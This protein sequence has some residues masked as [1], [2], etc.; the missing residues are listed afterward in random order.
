MKFL[1]SKIAVIGTGA[2]GLGILTA[3]LKK[4]NIEI[5]VFDVFEE[6]DF[7]SL[8]KATELKVE[9]FYDEIYSEIK[10]KTSFKFPPPKTHFTKPLAKYKLDGKPGLFKSKSLGGLTNYWGGTSLAFTDNELENWHISRKDLNPYYS[11]LSKLIG[12]SSRNDKLDSYFGEN[13]ATNPPYKITR[14]FDKL[15]ES[16]NSTSENEDNYQVISG[17]NRVA[18]ETREGE[19]NSCIYCGECLA[20]CFSDSIY[21][22]R[23]TIEKYLSDDRVK[24]VKGK[25]IRVEEGKV[26]VSAE[27][28]VETYSGFS[29]IFIGAGCPNSTEIV[30]RSTGLTKS[31]KMADNAVYVF[32]ILYLGKLDY[33][34]VNEPYVSLCNLIFGFIPKSKDYKFA[35]AQVYSNFDYMWRYNIPEPIWKVV[36]SL[37]SYSRARVFW[38]RLYV[39]GEESQSYNCELVNDEINFSGA[40]KASNKNINELM[41]SVRNA[42]NK[43][44]FYIPPVSPILQKTNSHYS[45]TFPYKGN[46]LD[47]SESAEFLPNVYLCDSSVFPDLPAVSLTFT[48]MANANRIVSEA[49][50]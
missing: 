35:Q 30:L 49:M 19:V 36:K 48:I 2:A 8:A 5:T 40:D 29:K 27:N 12:I 3:L 38:A 20:G 44:G 10:S 21:S 24:T 26:T 39:S 13:F 14:M 33:K 4:K 15:D 6:E 7:P 17:T 31:E 22:T 9:K 28:K 37:V 43:N 18:L 23:K 1:K 50:N 45:S 32:P 34:V 42:V 47:V 25:V 16:T 11:E 46:L 41:K